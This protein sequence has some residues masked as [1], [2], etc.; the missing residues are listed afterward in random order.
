MAMEVRLLIAQ[1]FTRKKK[2][3]ESAFTPTVG[4]LTYSSKGRNS[5]AELYTRFDA[6]NHHND[7]GDFRDNRDHY[8]RVRIKFMDGRQ[9]YSYLNSIW[10]YSRHRF[11]LYYSHSWI[12]FLLG[13]N[14]K[15]SQSGIR[16]NRDR[17]RNRNIFY[18]YILVSILSINCLPAKAEDP[19]V[20]NVSNPVA[21]ATG[22]VTNSA[23]QFQNNGAPS[24][25]VLGPN[26]SCNPGTVTFSP[27]YMGN[28]VTPFDDTMAQQSYTVSENWG[29]QLNFMIPLDGS[30]IEQCK[31]IA[32][33][34]EL[35]MQLNYELVRID[36]CTK[37]MQRGFMLRPGT[38]VAKL[39]Q[40]VIPI[41]QW[42]KEV[43]A[44]QAKANPQPPPTKKW[45]QLWKK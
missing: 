12:R 17:A 30:V 20:N 13:N 36:N 42:K 43:L 27:F 11:S 19:E 40:D 14:R 10:G 1:C 38:R 45:W 7:P 35:K 29:A 41:S 33:K 31:S 32:R 6:I 16:S 25:Q 8:L 3:E 34:Q 37:F 2:N 44:A 22:N 28:H 9:Y 15:S 26:I 21:A 18:Y 4:L 23:V 24:R 39:C 5:N